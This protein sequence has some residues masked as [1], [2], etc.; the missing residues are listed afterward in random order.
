MLGR[1]LIYAQFGVPY[2]FSKLTKSENS[3][4][5]YNANDCDYN[6]FELLKKANFFISGFGNLVLSFVFPFVAVHMHL[7]VLAFCGTTVVHIDLSFI[8]Q[9]NA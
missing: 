4:K 9:M 3:Y 2:R 8:K 6:T 7:C 5:C 1:L